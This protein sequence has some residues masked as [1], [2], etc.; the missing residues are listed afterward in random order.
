MMSIVVGITFIFVFLMSKPLMAYQLGE[1]YA[2]NLGVNIKR[3]RVSGIAFKP[4][5]RMYSGAC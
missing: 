2:V 3:I 1:S 5:F 4:A